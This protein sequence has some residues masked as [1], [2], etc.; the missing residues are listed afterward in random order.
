[1]KDEHLIVS[2]PLLRNNDFFTPIDDEIAALIVLTISAT[3][4][5]VILVQAMKLTEL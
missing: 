1:M 4:N 3:A 5:S 2:H